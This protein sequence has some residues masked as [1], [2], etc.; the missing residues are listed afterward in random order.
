MSKSALEVFNQRPSLINLSK[1]DPIC[2]KDSCNKFKISI[3][4]L[5]ILYLLCYVPFYYLTS[6]DPDKTHQ[7]NAL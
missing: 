1:T 7:L 6:I 4:V 5:F 3:F 2:I